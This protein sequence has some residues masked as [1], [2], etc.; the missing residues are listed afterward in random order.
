VAVQNQRAIQLDQALLYNV[1]AAGT[2]CLCI[3]R[4][5][6]GQLTLDNLEVGLEQAPCRLWLDAEFSRPSNKHRIF[7][8]DFW[9]VLQQT[10]IDR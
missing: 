6:A 2:P 4:Q 5:F 9:H 7:W 1:V 8:Q 3:Q 10:L